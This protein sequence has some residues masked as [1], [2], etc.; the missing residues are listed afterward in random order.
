ME[1]PTKR[2]DGVQT[3]KFFFVK[4][5]KNIIGS[6]ECLKP[7]KSCPPTTII[8]YLRSYKQ[9]VVSVK[10]T[11][12]SVTD[13]HQNCQDMKP[14]S[15]ILKQVKSSASVKRLVKYL[16]D[17]RENFGE[18]IRDLK[19]RIN[20]NNIQKT[21][22]KAEIQSMRKSINDFLNSLEKEI[23]DGLESKHS[24]LKSEMNTLL[25]QIKH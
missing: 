13:K 18:I 25:E 14:L 17:L 24:K 5:M 2:S 21:K 12:L 10:T 20:T 23:L 16:N 9:L 6:Q 7:M 4:T 8:I 19:S 11:R 15:D 1:T 3:V 22:A